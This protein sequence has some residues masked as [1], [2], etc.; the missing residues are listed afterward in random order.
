MKMI[1]TIK[2]GWGGSSVA[3]P[4]PLFDYHS[5]LTVGTMPL[6]LGERSIYSSQ[7]AVII[8]VVPN[9]FTPVEKAS[10]IQS[11]WI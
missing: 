7:T 11:N 6:C 9:F 5:H 8:A 4:S 2:R 1:I 3:R 10:G